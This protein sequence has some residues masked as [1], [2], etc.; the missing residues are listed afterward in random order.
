MSEIT[1]TVTVDSNIVTITP[2]NNTVVFTPEDFQLNIW[3][4]GNLST[5]IPAKGTDGA[6]QYRNGDYIDGASTLS[7]ND[8]TFVLSMGGTQNISIVGGANGEVLRTDGLG[9]LTW[10]SYI[11]N[12]GYANNSNHSSYSDVATLANTATVAT[13]A[14]YANNAGNATIASTA[15]LAYGINGAIANMRIAGGSSGQYLQTDGSGSLSWA[16]VTSAAAPVTQLVAGTGISVSNGGLGVVTITNT[17]GSGTSGVSKIIAGTNVTIS[18]TGAGGTGDVTINASGGGGGG[19]ATALTGL[20]D[21]S[22]SSPTNGQSLVYNSSINKWTNQTL[23]GI[24]KVTIYTRSGSANAS[25][26]NGSITLV[27]RSGNI[28]IAAS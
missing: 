8:S 1:T 5:D 26:T 7:Y 6:V 11:A 20:T 12:A 16:T 3:A 9:N 24:D 22:I 10:T 27:G 19:G 25:I 23:V 13:T 21:V 28:S 15:N 17:G 2:E 18:S 4:T 14:G